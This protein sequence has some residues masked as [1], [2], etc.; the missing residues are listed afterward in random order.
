MVSPP[1]GSEVSRAEVQL[2]LA[3]SSD[4]P[5]L[6]WRRA[7]WG[8]SDMGS[9]RVH[10][11]WR[12]MNHGDLCSDDL[13]FLLLLVVL[14]STYPA[15]SPARM[16]AISL[17]VSSEYRPMGELYC[18]LWRGLTAAA[19]LPGE[20]TSTGWDEADGRPFTC[21]DWG[22][23]WRR[24]HEGEGTEKPNFLTAGQASAGFIFLFQKQRS[25]FLN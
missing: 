5:N 22:T 2:Q 18:L 8:A 10:I 16:A 13:W 6:L 24:G 9:S 1:W 19:L 12:N 7:W 21:T 4:W 17:R 11:S 3:S 15:G 25:H 20:P 14:L 23:R